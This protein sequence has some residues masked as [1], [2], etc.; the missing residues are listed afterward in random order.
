MSY[1]GIL[2]A[3]YMDAATIR[4]NLTYGNSVIINLCGFQ[5]EGANIGIDRDVSRSSNNYF[6]GDDKVY[7]DG[8]GIAGTVETS[9]VNKQAIN[10]VVNFMNNVYA[11]FGNNIYIYD[12]V[13]K[14]WS[15]SLA[16]AGKNA[17]RTNSIGLY[18]VFIGNAP[19]LITAWNTTSA[20][21]QSA[22]LNGLTGV[23]TLGATSTTVFD[24]SDSSGGILNE[25]QHQDRIYFIDSNTTTIG[26]YDFLLD[27]F[28]TISWSGTVR[29]PMDF[30]TF[31]E[32]LW[33]LNKDDSLNINLHKIH[34]TFTELLGLDVMSRGGPAGVGG[35]QANSALSTTNN[36]E[37]R[38]FLFVD[39]VRRDIDD[40]PVMWCENIAHGVIEG[41]VHSK[42]GIVF[43]P[44]VYDG[45]GLI[46][47]AN[48]SSPNGAFLSN[49]FKIG[50]NQE[51]SGDDEEH[52]SKVEESVFRIFVDQRER[53]LSPGGISAI[54]CSSRFSIGCAGGDAFAGVAAGGG[55]DFSLM[56]NWNWLGGGS[57]DGTLRSWGGLASWDFT[58]GQVE[59]R[60]RAYPHEKIGGG[61]RSSVILLDG[62]KNID[63]VFRG[64]DTTDQDGVMRIFYQLIT[65]DG[66]PNGTNVSV[67]WYYD[68]NL[69]APESQI[70]P[71]GTSHGSVSGIEIVS[72]AADSGQLYHFDWDIL[73]VSLPYG[74]KINLNGVVRTAD[75]TTTP[76]NSPED[77]SGLS[78]WLEADDE[79]TISSGVGG[80]ISEWRDKSGGSLTGLQQANG[81]QQPV[82]VPGANNGL[83]GVSFTSANSEY[84]FASG[85]P[86]VHEPFTTFV[87]FE[88][89]SVGSRQTMFSISDDDVFYTWERSPG[90]GPSG[91]I[92]GSGEFYNVETSGDVGSVILSS[93]DLRR[94]NDGIL[95]RELPLVSGA[96]I[97]EAKLVWWREEVIQSRANYHPDGAFPSG[98][99]QTVNIITQ[100]QVSPSGF[101]DSSGNLHS[102]TTVGRF[103]GAQ[104]SGVY[105]DVGK[106]FD[107][108]IYEIA[109]YNR[110]LFDLEIDRFVLYAS[111]KYNLV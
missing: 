66:V 50:A 70:T 105:N 65:T 12:Q 41:S 4:G 91:T 110:T 99:E 6:S 51:G 31:N 72:I 9:N 69:H 87:I 43:A 25:V 49:P 18:P 54:N 73:A 90:A 8:V 85:S 11:L 101:I 108:T 42:H 29:H 13:L 82:F 92:V 107:G 19:H 26:W 63:I 93:Q 109:T 45:A 36:F 84:L 77:L 86:L 10:R 74:K 81:S 47:G 103:S 23:W 60:Q 71:S 48:I 55:G 97:N 102:N 20:T 5:K 7:L 38:N 75:A 76:I 46:T 28:G 98:L 59:A 32:E 40:K 88:P 22:K 39:N 56:V 68:D 80:P 79:T 78:L 106:Y 100:G 33:C 95:P 27:T 16:L 24:P 104:L 35:I 21:W 64:T 15:V 62:N 34:K 52:I 14:T 58:G 17:A 89:S 111:G 67:K 83:G 96:I 2:H 44:F 30:V 37:G 53:E 94:T 57:P 3:R 61:A 1:E